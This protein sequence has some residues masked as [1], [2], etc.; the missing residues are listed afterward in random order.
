MTK[1]LADGSYDGH[2][3]SLFFPLPNGTALL[4]RLNGV[5]T[6]PEA[7][8]TLNETVQAKKSK[9]IIIP[10]RNWLKS[11]QRFHVSWVI[12]G[13]QDQTTFIKGANM[14]DVAGESMKDFKI[15]FMAYKTGMYKF[16][17]TFKNESSGEYLFYRM[18]IQATEP[19]VLERIELS[20][21]IRE[22]VSKVVTI[23]NPTDNEVTILRSQFVYVNEYVEVTPDT[24]KIPPKSEGGFEINYRP[25]TMSEQEVDLTLKHPILGDF[26][27]K[28][29][30][31]GLP[32]SS[33]RSLAFKC[34]LGQDLVQ[35]FKF[36]HYLKK[37]TNYAMKIEKLDA[38]GGP[39]EFKLDAA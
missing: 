10:V 8:A 33:Q 13:D 18:Q 17:I 34:A 26:K 7:E 36:T 32:A 28:L 15:N 11:D 27:Y 30:L 35:A 19:D 2:K 23:E 9:F 24:L 20:S 37:P 6:E 22:T 39:S 5:A 12:E 4:Y 16:V 1:K 38:T 21:A 3:G 31:K 29:L 25:L 14:V